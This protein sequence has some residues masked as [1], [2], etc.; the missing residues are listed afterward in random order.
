MAP[1]SYKVLRLIE[2]TYPNVEAAD[3]DMKRWGVPPV[4]AKAVVR[5]TTTIRSTII[6]HPSEDEG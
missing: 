4:G 3:A 6:Q 5:G 1:M 2:Y